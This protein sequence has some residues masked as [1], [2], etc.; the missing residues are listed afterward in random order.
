MKDR[1][2]EYAEPRNG[3]REL[4]IA[5]NPDTDFQQIVDI[6]R[7]SWVVPKQPGVGGCQPCMS[8]LDRLVVQNG[9]L[10]TVR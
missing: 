3:T 10:E 8:G 6:L 9:R 4:K 5:V 1:H 2:K 7:E